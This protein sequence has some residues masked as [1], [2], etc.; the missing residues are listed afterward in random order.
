MA[1][2]RNRLLHPR[3]RLSKPP[4]RRGRDDDPIQRKILQPCIVT[5]TYPPEIN[6]VANTVR[7]WVEGL[8]Q[9][10]HGIHLI[11]PRQK[12][13]GPARPGGER[14][15]RETPS[16]GLPIPGYPG[17]RFGLPIYRQLR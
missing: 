4:E 11:R 16:P 8:E 7:Y 6:G 13:D 5:E 17:L 15:R 12:G 2:W 3:P 10:G 14:H 1:V 9:R